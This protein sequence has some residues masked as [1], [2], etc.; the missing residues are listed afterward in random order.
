MR[1]RAS[2]DD[3]VSA[4]GRIGGRIQESSAVATLIAAAVEEQGAATQEIARNVTEAASSAGEVTSS[5]SGVADAASETGAADQVLSS[6]SE[7]SLR[8]EHLRSE[9]T[10]FLATVRTA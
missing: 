1:R 3:A 9:V 8:S 4:I 10:H 7:L 6:A 2:T 5:I